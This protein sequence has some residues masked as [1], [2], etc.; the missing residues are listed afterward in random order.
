MP[1]AA[2]ALR[3]EDPLGLFESREVEEVASRPEGVEDVAVP[4]VEG[5][6]GKNEDSVAQPIENALTPPSKDF[7]RNDHPQITLYSALGSFEKRSMA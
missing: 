3:H 5:R 1:A 4:E 7:L 6:C 2:L